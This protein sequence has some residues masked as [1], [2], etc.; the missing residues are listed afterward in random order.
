MPSV[1][2][3]AQAD[4]LARGVLKTRLGLKPKEN[5]TIE[6][7]TSS[8]P[9]AAGFVRQAR[10]MGAR[11]L[12]HYEDENAYWHAVDSGNAELI[13]TPGDHEW[14]ALENT[15]VYVYFWGPENQS[16]L[17]AL[18]ESTQEKLYAFNSRWYDLASKN[19]VRGAR[20]GIA[21]V[22][23]E[24]A[25]FWG[26]SLAR[27][28]KELLAAS[29]RDPKDLAHDAGRLQSALSRSALIRIQH[30]N[31]TDLTLA[32]A[33]RKPTTYVGK[34][35]PQ[36]R[37][38]R[39]GTM[40]SVPDANVLVS[41]DEGTAE[42]TLVANRPT[43]VLGSPLRGGRWTFADGRLTQASFAE[44]ERSFQK[45]FA[46]APAGKDRPSF[47]E[48]GMDPAIHASP[49]FEESERG[50]VTI[51]VGGN[52]GFGGKTKCDFVSYITLADATVSL[53]GRSIARGGRIL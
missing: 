16:R 30:P 26:V 7:Y 8:L 32:L 2:T 12:L 20:M 15:D 53:D 31:G 9:W 23:E 14:A 11:P 24:N 36:S 13:G 44:G 46:A 10:K 1:P 47:F 21:R 50:A 37:K 51:G 40:A 48:I 43:L 29:S 18:P 34:V 19:G 27:W 49:T 17:R 38:T 42:G 6:A 4:Q 45:D 35:T 28:R 39:F 22:T 33:K 41:L 25:R 52:S 5:V 3:E